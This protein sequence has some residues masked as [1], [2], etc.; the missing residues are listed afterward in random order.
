M[1]RIYLALV[2]LAMLLLAANLL[3]GLTLGDFGAASRQYQLAR[4][5]YDELGHANSVVLAKAT[6]ELQ[7]STAALRRQRSPFEVH[8]WLGIGASL[9][10]LLVNSISI[11]YFVGTSRW[12]REVVDA[13]GLNVNLGAK[14]QRLKRRAFP[15][16]LLGIACVLV[17]AGLGAASDPA[18]LNP[19]AADWVPYHWGLA[20]V[21]LFVIAGCFGVQVAAISENYRVI[22]EIVAA[23]EQERQRRRLARAA[24]ANPEPSGAA[25]A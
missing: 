23:A 3:V 17:I 11:T 21:G 4:Q 9:V 16:A 15:F 5:R 24:V 18:T 1:S 14:C 8:I 19:N 22:N 13:F 7:D 20:L 2:L 12:A 25:S 10:V 6:R